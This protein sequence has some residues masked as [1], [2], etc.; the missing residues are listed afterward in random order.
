MFDV[1]IV[2]QSFLYR[3]QPHRPRHSH[4]RSHSYAIINKDSLTSPV[5]VP[6][7]E[8]PLLADANEHGQHS[9]DT[10][11]QEHLDVQARRRRD[12]STVEGESPPP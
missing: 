10:I 3:P 7:D 4:S 8:R 5:A 2:V 6:E 1:T 9:E 12:M 11:R